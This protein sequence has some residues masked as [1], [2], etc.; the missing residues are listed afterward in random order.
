M[1]EGSFEPQTQIAKKLPQ[2]VSVSAL[3]EAIKFN[4]ESGFRHVRVEGEVS[5]FRPAHSGHL[6]F[7]LKD[8]QASLSAAL[9]RWGTHQKPSP[10]LKE[11]ALIICSGRISVFAPRGSYQLIVDKIEPAGEGALALAFEQLKQKLLTQ[12]LFAPER[13]RPLPKFATSICII[14]SPTG[15][16][17]QDIRQI[18]ERRCVHVHLL[19]IPTLVQGDLASQQIIA[20][21][22]Y[23]NKTR[24]APLIVLARGGGSAEDLWCFNSEALAWAILSSQIPVISAVGH[25]TDFTIADFVADL[26]APTPSAAAEILS[27]HWVQAR[28][29]L[30]E[31]PNRLLS[32]FTDSILPKKRLLLQALVA[33]CISPKERIQQQAQKLDEFVSRLKAAVQKKLSHLQLQFAQPCHK[34]DAL[35]PLKVLNRGYTLIKDEEGVFIKSA[36]ALQKSYTKSDGKFQITFFDGTVWVRLVSELQQPDC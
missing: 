30:A 21:I 2:A 23:A 5:N 8:A 7:T 32:L 27:Q 33:R 15:A 28:V 29:A 6:Y 12:G 19:V 20:A 24:L 3:T 16:V 36:Q 1:Q 18:L 9:F 26:R 31:I 22:E 35:S 4:L 10:F 14:T 11:G 25:E 13:K 17:L 34:L